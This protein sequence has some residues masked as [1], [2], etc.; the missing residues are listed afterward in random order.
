[1]QPVNLA[2][3]QTIVHV[4]QIVLVA[5]SGTGQELLSGHGLG[6]GLVSRDEQPERVQF[7]ELV[8]LNVLD[9]QT[10]QNQLD[11]YESPSIG[12]IY[13]QANRVVSYQAPRS[14]RFQV[15]YDF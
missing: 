8:R 9:R 1:M 7:G 12:S 13:A 15:R 5:Q 10:V 11:Y 3:H 6:G 2:Q 14:Y 4:H